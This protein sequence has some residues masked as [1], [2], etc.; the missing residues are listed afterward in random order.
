MNI[1][2]TADGFKAP[3]ECDRRQ[4]QQVCFFFPQLAFRMKTGLNRAR[5]GYFLNYASCSLKSE[6]QLCSGCVWNAQEPERSRFESH[7]C[8][9]IV[10]WR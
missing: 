4:C 1:N 2:R 5:E 7:S 10:V 6:V 8:Y 3:N 9:P